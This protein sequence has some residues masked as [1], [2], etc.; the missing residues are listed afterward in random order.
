MRAG[1]K[2]FLR[3][4]IAWIL[5]ML[6]F[7]LWINILYILD[8]GLKAVS[9]TYFNIVGIIAIVL[10]LVVRYFYEMKR[11]RYFSGNMNDNTSIRLMDREEL[12]AF[13]QYYVEI[14]EQ[15]A[16][17]NAQEINRLSV[18]GQEKDDMLLAWVHEVKTPL[19]AM[20]LLLDNVEDYKIRNKLEHE[21][22]RIYLLLD[23]QL[24][25]TRLDD[26]EKDMYL[27]KVALQPVIFTEI[28]GLQ[29][30]CMEKGIG[31]DT[32]NL[33][34][35]VLCDSKWLAFIVR[36]VLSNAVKYSYANTDICITSGEDGA[37]HRLLQIEDKGIGIAA[38]D[39]PRVFEKSYTGT[40]GRES[41][42]ATGMGLYLAKSVAQQLG[43]SITLT[44]QEDVG[45]K[46]I[47]KFPLENEYM[48]IYGR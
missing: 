41:A 21:W 32:E 3:Q 11:M 13:Q 38:A 45:T 46:V 28:R 12:S 18:S 27:T 29:A 20:Q 40:A 2:L 17:R 4:Y 48:K 44:S 43:I 15:Q 25:S 6:G 16:E 8:F 31:F 36:Q 23:Q 26:I 35:E 33:Y 47:I 22:L 7:M 30:W 37:G 10:F 19:T 34:G 42:K 1:I 14:L 24:H 39:L 5:F 9:I